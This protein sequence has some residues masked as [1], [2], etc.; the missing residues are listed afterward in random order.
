M[1]T[2]RWPVHSE[3]EIAAVTE[4]LRSG[5]T[6]YWT[7]LEG[8]SFQR[9]F[10]AQFSPDTLAIA[11][12]NGTT[13]LECALHALQALP[14][15]EVIIPCRTFMATASAC[16]MN[17][18]KPVL[19]DI[20]QGTLNVSVETLEAR[21]TERTKAVIF[22][23]FAGR[24][25]DYSCY[26]WARAKGLLIID[27]CAHAHGAQHVPLVFP[28]GF[29]ADIACFSFCVGKIMSTGGEGGMCVT[30]NEKLFQRMYAY[31]DHG[32]YQMVGSKDMTQFQ[33]TVEEFGSNLRMTE[34]QAAIGRIQLR[35][36]PA[37]IERRRWIAGEYNKHF[38]CSVNTHPGHSY[39][40]YIMLVIDR[41][42]IL[43]RLN[44]RGIPARLGGCPN[45]GREQAFLKAHWNLPCPNADEVGQYTLAL[46]V[47]PTMTDEE[48][49]TVIQEVRD[50][51]K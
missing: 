36:L 35:N 29:F 31:R 23:H 42:R 19:A 38:G 33:W 43:A 7:G 41:D 51:C 47:Y 30:N 49:L 12:S 20:D 13:A 37:Q 45:I 22:V 8:Q 2:T 3:E 39:Y 15:D 1:V 11:V 32:R 24:P 14:G 10:A 25:V 26:V 16:V 18:F 4:V 5:K 48:V 6:N 9:E 50:A 27:D 17:G 21:L 46:P 34:M 40:L 44:E 28:A